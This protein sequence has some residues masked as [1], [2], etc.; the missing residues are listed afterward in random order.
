MIRILLIR[1]ATN[2]LLGRELYGR[3]P[4][5]HLNDEGRRQAHSLAQ[6]LAQRYVLTEVISSPIERALETAAPIAEIQKI[7][8]TIDE[9]IT[10]VD[11]GAWTGKSFEELAAREDWHIFNRHRSTTWPPDGEATLEVQ[12]RA[13][14]SV[15]RAVHRFPVEDTTIALVTHGDVVRCTLMLLLGMPIDFIHRVEVSP[16]SVSEIHITHNAVTVCSI[17]E[18]SYAAASRPQKRTS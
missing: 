5:V 8:I 17:N 13:W 11:V 6:G 10:E 9:G 3:T 15:M 2:D 1:H 12:S 14:R 4:G 18:R 7:P 16:A